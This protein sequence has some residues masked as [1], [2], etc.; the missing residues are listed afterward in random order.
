MVGDVRHWQLTQPPDAELYF[1]LTQAAG[2]GM[3]M[4]AVRTLG[5][6]EQA[7]A[8]VRARILDV[9]PQQPVYH[10][11]PMARLLDDSLLA[12]STS[13]A[14]MAVFSA[15]ALVLSVVG[16]YGVVSYGVS[17]QM[18]EFGLR[19]AL[20]ATPRELMGL[21]VR[22]GALLVASGILMGAVVAPP[23]GA[24]LRALL[25][26]VTPNDPLTFAAAGGALLLLG[27]TAC[28]IPAWRAASTAPLS[29][30]RSE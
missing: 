17:Q 13:A 11:K 8:P 25:V 29:A 5:R 2:T 26:G 21:V 24:L 28:V 23:A 27:I 16:V 4:L 30:L 15:L 20:G 10:V 18:P 1:P 19:L 14:L 6:P 7:T 12:S 22:Q 9:D 3:M